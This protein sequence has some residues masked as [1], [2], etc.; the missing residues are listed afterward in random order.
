M[1]GKD[2]L[3]SLYFRSVD[4]WREWLQ[5]H[6]KKEMAAWLVIYNKKSTVPSIRWQDAIEHALCFGWVDS[7]ALKRDPESCYLRFTPRNPNS[8]WGKKNRERAQR[9]I[10][11]GLMTEHGQELIDKA[12]ATGKWEHQ[13]ERKRA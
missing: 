3:Q 6:C 1:M 4:E 13:N 2:F 7:K 11:Q 8:S 9:M 12:Q 10:D 5:T